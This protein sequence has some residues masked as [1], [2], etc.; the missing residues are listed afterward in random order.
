MTCRQRTHG[1]RAPGDAPAVPDGRG[2][3]L[4][5]PVHDGALNDVG[6]TMVEGFLGE[7]G[8]GVPARYRR[9]APGA[10]VRIE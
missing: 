6:T 1:P 3:T 9:L 4:L 5:L 10:H 2:D 8:P 7:R